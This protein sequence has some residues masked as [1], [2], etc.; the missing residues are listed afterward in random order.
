VSFLNEDG[1]V[2][3][4]SSGTGSEIVLK[5]GKVRVSDGDVYCG[6]S[7][8]EGLAAGVDALTTQDDA[9]DSRMNTLNGT[10]AD[11]Q[12]NLNT[13]DATS[14]GRF[15]TIDTTLTS[16]ASTDASLS[17]T[18]AS[19][20]SRIDALNVTDAQLKATDETLNTRISSLNATDAALKGVDDGLSSRIDAL[21]DIYVN[22]LNVTDK[23]LI[24]TDATLGSRIDDLNSTQYELR[25]VDTGLSSRLDA[26]EPSHEE[27]ERIDD[28]VTS[29]IDSLN[30]TDATMQAKDAS[31]SNRIDALNAT[32]QALS[33]IDASLSAQIASL[34]PPKCTEPGGDELL[35]NGTHWECACLNN[36]FAGRSCE[37]KCLAIQAPLRGLMGD[38]EQEMMHGSSC[39][40]TCEE[41]YYVDGN[42]TCSFGNLL[43]GICRP[44]PVLWARFDDPTHVGKDY[45]ELAIDMEATGN[46]VKYEYDDERGGVLRVTNCDHLQS[47]SY[48]ASY[49]RGSSSYT[50]AFWFKVN[51]SSINTAYNQGWGPAGF[52][53]TSGC[54]RKT[55]SGI[56]IQSS[57]S[58]L[59]KL[60]T[61]H[62]C[63]DMFGPAGGNDDSLG[64]DVADGTWH[65]VAVTYDGVTGIETIYE[66]FAPLAWRN[67]GSLNIQ[68]GKVYVGDISQLLVGLAADDV[69][70]VLSPGGLID[71]FTLFNTALS[72]GEIATMG[73]TPIVRGGDAVYAVSG[74]DTIHVFKSGGFFT[75]VGEP[76]VVEI[77]VV[78]GGG[79]G[80][81]RSGGGGGAGGLMHVVNLVVTP[82]TYPVVVGDGGAG[83]VGS[84][85]GTVGQDGANSS[86]H[87]FEAVGGGGGGSDGDAS[88]RDSYG[89]P[90]G[91]GG[92]GR[93]G[94]DGGQGVSGQGNHGGNSTTGHWNGGGGGGAGGSG[95]NGVIG[96]IGDGGTGVLKNIT[97][98]STFYGGGG[99]GGLHSSDD[100]G[101]RRSSGGAGGGGYGGYLSGGYDGG[102]GDSNTGGGG[103]GGATRH[104][105][106][107]RGGNGGSGVVIIRHK[108]LLESLCTSSSTSSCTSSSA[109]CVNRAADYPKTAT[110]WDYLSVPPIVS[111]VTQVNAGSWSDI[112]QV[113]VDRGL[114]LCQSD[115]FCT[116]RVPPAGID[117]SQHDSWIAV[118]DSENEWLT[119]RRGWGDRICKTH[120][121]IAGSKP[122][123]G[124]SSSTY[125]SGDMYR[126]GICCGNCSS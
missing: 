86:F 42:T 76:I 13:L 31:L 19:L 106:G 8:T 58:R 45:S 90:G 44:K 117:I 105:S 7:S 121:Q 41:G 116:D 89:R 52:G 66:D 87:G 80:G 17:A 126:A 39:T 64:S 94:Y 109:S 68:P 63:D 53:V 46:G 115:Q 92:G 11:L 75:V 101:V 49:P 100:A 25:G 51:I 50:Y 57:S 20:S 36:S 122:D 88:G 56:G 15:A 32:S 62:W 78:A 2:Y 103:G 4:E 79:G 26:L 74:G 69:K 30:A 95:G 107:G 24:V 9:F 91:S 70:C 102:D 43:S 111:G 60:N 59:G 67:L 18:D 48:A 104:G 16:L 27:Y 38:C 114:Q 99:G 1:D 21:R 125:T 118:G 85:P 3:V 6:I 77:L 40:F 113:C 14:S 120:T 10:H 5:T 61:G 108:G 83:G 47:S 93:Y 124:N 71:E 110:E 98:S 22:E 81:G 112:N 37:K 35:F 65:H 73:D 34:T 119:F 28:K 97:G 55:L 23:Q 72:H 29:L 96:A 33:S 54:G 84:F 82:G 123:W 12:G